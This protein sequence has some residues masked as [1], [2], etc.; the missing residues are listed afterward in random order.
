MGLDESEPHWTANRT[1]PHNETTD[2]L[3]WTDFNR[4]SPLRNQK[5]NRNLPRA[6]ADGYDR[7][8][9]RFVDTFSLESLLYASNQ[10]LPAGGVQT[11]QKKGPRGIPERIGGYPRS[12]G[13][14]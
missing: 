10:I 8:M 4:T 5:T 6:R 12:P 7:H 9:G 2:R 1:K 14:E 11:N 3:L 13:P